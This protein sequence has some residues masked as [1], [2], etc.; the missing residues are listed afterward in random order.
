MAT[1]STVVHRSVRG[2]RGEGKTYRGR[3]SGLGR[4]EIL[5]RTEPLDNHNAVS[6]EGRQI[7]REVTYRHLGS[8]SR[9][10]SR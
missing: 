6:I 8:I 2:D 3:I 10:E 5:Q 9:W 1:D 7:G 4:L